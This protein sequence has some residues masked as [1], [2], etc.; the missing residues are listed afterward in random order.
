MELIQFSLWTKYLGSGNGHQVND[1]L[2]WEEEREGHW[3]IGLSSPGRE[4]QVVQGNNGLSSVE[5]RSF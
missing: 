2:G 4:I 5:L 1:T 3:A